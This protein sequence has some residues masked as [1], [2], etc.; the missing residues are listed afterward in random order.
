MMLLPPKAGTC[1]ACAVEHSDDAPHNAQSIYYQY[2]F[3]GLRDRWPTWADAIA[4][5]SPSIQAFWKAKLKEKSAWTEPEDSDPIADPPAES[6]SQA[7]GDPNDG[8][9]GGK[10]IVSTI[11]IADETDDT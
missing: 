7:I 3:Y 2:R 9:F 11:R 1:P 10:Q 6:F 8:C 4:H 5:C